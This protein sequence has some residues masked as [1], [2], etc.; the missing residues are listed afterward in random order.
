[1]RLMANAIALSAK[2]RM[3]S[4]GSD[5]VE[6]RT[7]PFA[8]R[9]YQTAINANAKESTHGTGPRQSGFGEIPIAH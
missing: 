6:T 5:S 2:F 3:S 4:G 9:G 1:M 7:H 8:R